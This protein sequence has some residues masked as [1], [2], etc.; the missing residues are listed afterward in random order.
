[1]MDCDTT[2]VEPDIAL[3]KYKF[4]VGGGML[5]MANRIV[6]M[7]LKALGYKKDAI[8]K[9]MAHIQQWDTIED[10]DSVSAVESNDYR[11][12]MNR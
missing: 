2:G 10:D 4:L 12:F 3:V 11:G 5:K 1:M 6:P 8:E 9:I 7:G